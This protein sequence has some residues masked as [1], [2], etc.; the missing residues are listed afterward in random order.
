MPPRVKN[1]SLA[2]VAWDYRLRIIKKHPSPC[3]EQSAYRL[4]QAF[5]AGVKWARRHKAT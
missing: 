4:E 2:T 3:L 1:R 5:I